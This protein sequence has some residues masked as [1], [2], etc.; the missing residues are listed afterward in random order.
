MFDILKNPRYLYTNDKHLIELIS[1]NRLNLIAS[2][3]N[4]QKNGPNDAQDK[5]VTFAS[6]EW[7]HM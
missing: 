1:S 3:R 5:H 2:S 4:L 6:D 7:W